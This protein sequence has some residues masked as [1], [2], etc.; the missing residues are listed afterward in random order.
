MVDSSKDYE[1]T[2]TLE[3]AFMSNEFSPSPLRYQAPLSALPRTSLKDELSKLM[4]YGSVSSQ[5]LRDLTT[6]ERPIPRQP[7]LEEIPDAGQ[8]MDDE[9][10]KSIVLER[11]AQEPGK[12]KPQIIGKT[13]MTK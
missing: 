9:D 8:S 1:S 10:A 4:L 11:V 2:T 3:K 12:P 7:I 13:F 5:A 6:P